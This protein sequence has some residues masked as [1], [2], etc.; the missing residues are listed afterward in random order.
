[1]CAGAA[2]GGVLAEDVEG[3]KG[4]EEGNKGN[5]ADGPAHDGPNFDFAARGVGTGRPPEGR[6]SIPRDV[7]DPT[8]CQ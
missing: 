8:V 3:E 5:T 2:G 1:M 6:G 4:E 7:E